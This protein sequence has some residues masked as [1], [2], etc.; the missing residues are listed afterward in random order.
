MFELNGNAIG[1]EDIQKKA[2][3]KGYNVDEYIN[4]L[5]EKGLVEKTEG[6]VAN[7]ATVVPQTP[8][9]D[10]A[11]ADTSSEQPKTKLWGGLVPIEVNEVNDKQFNRDGGFFEDLV[12]AARQGTKTGQS[13]EE[14][15]D[16]Y[17]QGKS[18]SD[19]QLQGFIDA[20]NALNQV[21]ETNEQIEFRKAQEKEGGGFWGTASALADNPGFL[22]QMLVSS[23][24]TMLTSLGSEEVAV[25]T[26]AGAGVGSV[27]PVVGTMVGG[28][29]GLV[30]AMET[31]L[32]MTDLIKDEL[33]GKDFNKNNVRE[34]LNDE[35]LFN[36]I[37]LRAVGRGVTIGAF[38]GVSMGLSR[39]VGSKI[40]KT[41]KATPISK[42]LQISSAATGIETT[43]AFVGETGGQ[44]VAGQDVD[45]G[46]SLLEGIG[47]TKGVINTSDIIIKALNKPKY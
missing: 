22:P 18:I 9:T 19:E 12:V 30:G 6:A 26:G 16:V 1:L 36:K 38:E 46:E 15:Y 17:R 42:S 21:G 40:L 20:T 11:S 32:T 13:V 23:Y 8:D 7:D 10:L 28:L 31:A 29:T 43:G 5:K 35:K 45:L 41:S 44:I 33:K 4:F 34:I 47:E 25:A 14:A 37:R 3:E 27:V 2:K 24:A 39:G